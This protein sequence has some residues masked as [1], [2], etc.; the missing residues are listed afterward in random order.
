[1]V[2]KMMTKYHPITVLSIIFFFGLIII[3]PITY[4]DLSSVNFTNLPLSIVFKILFVVL[5]TTCI[6]YFLNIFALS[7]LKSSVVAFYIYLQ[8]LLATIISL[9]WGK[10]VLSSIKI[11]AASLIFLGIYFVVYK[12]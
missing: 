7:K 3:L 2:K 12:R 8:P 11:I 9:F 4:D 10:D 6:A 1:M 5:F